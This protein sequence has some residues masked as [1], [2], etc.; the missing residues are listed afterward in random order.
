MEDFKMERAT[1][2]I[3]YDCTLKCK[4]CSNYSPYVPL[5]QRRYPLQVCTK[6]ID[7]FFRIITYFGIY[8][9]S[10]AE[11]LLQTNLIELLENLQN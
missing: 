11:P 7:K 4:L 5:D 6:A 3:T 1:I 8:T 9:I 10:G 2:E